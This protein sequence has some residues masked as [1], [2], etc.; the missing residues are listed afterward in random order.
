MVLVVGCA[1]GPEPPEGTVTVPFVC[2][3]CDGPDLLKGIC[4]PIQGG[5]GVPAFSSNSVGGGKEYYCDQTKYNIQCGGK[6]Y[7]LPTCPYYLVA[8]A[9]DQRMSFP[10]FQIT[11]S[12]WPNNDSLCWST[13]EGA[14]TFYDQLD[15]ITGE[16]HTT[17][18]PCPQQSWGEGYTAWY[19]EGNGQYKTVGMVNANAPIIGG[20]EA[21]MMGLLYGLNHTNPPIR[22]ISW[23]A[24]R[25]PGDPH[26]KPNTGREG[27]E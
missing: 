9:V 25:N 5:E 26:C 20:P 24:W 2:F 16:Q 15:A 17:L 21:A 11:Y 4:C 18:I 3:N 13:P 8:T 7:P 14:K 27:P 12:A 6:C 23:Q 1:T 10:Q 19:E 22:F